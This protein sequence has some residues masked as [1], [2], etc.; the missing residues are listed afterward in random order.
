M[1]HVSRDRL[2]Q[3]A[4]ITISTTFCVRARSL[5]FNEIPKHVLTVSLSPSLF[6]SFLFSSLRAA[7]LDPLLVSRP[8]KESPFR[9][10][11]L[12]QVQ[13][14]SRTLRTIPSNHSLILFRNKGRG[15]TQPSRNEQC[16]AIVLPCKN[17]HSFTARSLL[18]RAIF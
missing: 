17:S 9:S 13:G 11:F 10:S 18:A 2:C 1:S 12:V 16:Y 3:T 4:R 6:L 5:R 7:I 15:K 14:I 8:E